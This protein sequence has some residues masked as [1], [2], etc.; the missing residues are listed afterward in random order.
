MKL[1]EEG[2][3][4]FFFFFSWG[5]VDNAWQRREEKR[6]CVCLFWPKEKEN[7]INFFFLFFFFFFLFLLCSIEASRVNVVDTVVVVVVV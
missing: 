5:L 2:Q 1:R 4:P 3:N 6:T 7:L